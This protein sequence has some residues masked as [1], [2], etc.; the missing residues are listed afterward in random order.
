VSHPELTAVDA[1]P[2]NELAADAAPKRWDDLTLAEQAQRVADAL[3]DEIKSQHPIG[4]KTHVAT[5]VLPGD[6]PP[7]IT[8]GYLFAANVCGVLR[9]AASTIESQA[10]ELVRL[11]GLESRL[12]AAVEKRERMG[13]ALN[14]RANNVTAFMRLILDG[15]NP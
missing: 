10:S 13:Y 14:S 8:I 5:S 15:G 12:R 9:N 4:G 2:L 6:E 7:T 11:R 1:P 3:W